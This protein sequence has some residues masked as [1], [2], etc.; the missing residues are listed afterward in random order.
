MQVLATSQGLQEL[1]QALK[2]PLIL[3]KMIFEYAASQID[4]DHK[5]PLRAPFLRLFLGDQI[6]PQIV[7]RLIANP[8]FLAKADQV[9]LHLIQRAVLQPP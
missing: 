4:I 8:T 1:F 9:S 2:G 3:W 5:H 6:N 7:T